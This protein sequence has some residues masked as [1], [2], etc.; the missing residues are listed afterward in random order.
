MTVRDDEVQADRQEKDTGA[1][2][3]GVKYLM[4]WKNPLEKIPKRRGT[5]IP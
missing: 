2:I 3:I 5:G 4:A 1:E